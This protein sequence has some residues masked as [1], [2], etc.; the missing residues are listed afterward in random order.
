MLQKSGIMA[1]YVRYNDESDI[2]F[3][4]NRKYV[5]FFVAKHMFVCYNAEKETNVR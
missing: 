3:D 1:F 5:R 2:F 4:E